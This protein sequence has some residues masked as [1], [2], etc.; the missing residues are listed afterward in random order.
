M[1]NWLCAW[2]MLS[3]IGISRF[4]HAAFQVDALRSCV[5]LRQVRRILDGFP[6][7]IEGAYVQ[8]WNR[9]LDE[10]EEN[11]SLL[12]MV[13]IWV[14]TA[15]RS[16]T[17]KELER[18]VSICPETFTFQAD[19]VVPGSTFMTMCRGLLVV[20]EESQIVRL[21]RE[22]TRPFSKLLY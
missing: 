14:L 3:L 20:E 6:S 4:L 16:M 9:I 11:L 21:V 7:Q 10:N 15:T 13:F 17:L 19:R 5:N 2:L 8:T 22:C 12:K 1:S 18:V